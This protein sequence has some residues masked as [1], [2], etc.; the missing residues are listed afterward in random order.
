MY[1]YEIVNIV[2]QKRYIG[3]TNN[4]KERFK[5]HQQ[6]YNSNKESNKVLYLAFKKYGIENFQ[7]NILK[8]AL[9]LDEAKAEEIRLISEYKTLSHENGYNVTKGGDYRSNYGEHNNTTIL[10]EA[11]VLEIIKRRETGEKGSDVYKNYTQITRSSFQRIWLGD[12]WSYLQ[13][14]HDI[15]I[16]KG[17]AKLSVSQVKQ[18]KELIANDTANSV[19]QQ[20]FNISYRDLWRIKTGRTYSNII[21]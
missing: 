15:V 19:I 16:A 8:S 11:D 1:V 21:F 18:I 20:T 10:A 17:N 6:K 3:I 14:K 4:V 13:S 2:N 5:Y 7:F 9:T 12:N